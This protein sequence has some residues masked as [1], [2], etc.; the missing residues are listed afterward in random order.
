M[1]TQEVKRKLTTILSAD[2]KGYSRLMGEDEESTARTL[3]TYKE[4]LA[5]LIQHH[6][7][8]VVDAPGDN[9]LA[10]FGSV[11]DAVECAVEIQKELKAR[12]ADLPENRTMEFRIGVNL[13]DVI[14]ERDKILGDGVNITA[15]MESLSEAGGIC[16]SGTAFDQVKHK[17]PVGYQFLGRQTVKNIT[18]PVRAY[19]VMMEPEAAGKVIGEKEPKAT[20]WVWRAIAIV[21]AMVLVAAGLIWNFYLRGSQIEA[22]RVDKMAFPLP[23]KPSI[24][25]LPF[26]NMSEDS[27]QEYLADGITENIISALSQVPNIFVIAR[28]STFTYKGKP[29]KVQR[30]AEELGVRYVLEGSVQ[31]A[32][33]AVRITAQLID[34]ISG[35]H[36]WSE[37][38]DREIK[39]IFALQDDI[40]MK[41]I[42]ALRVTLTEG[43][44]ARA[45]TK[46]TDNLQAY[47]RYLQA[48]AFTATHTREGYAQARRL[49]EEV[50][51]LDPQFPE[52]Y[53]QLGVI[54]FS[55]ASR[56]ISK[57]P[58]ESLRQA[59]E[60]FKKTIAMDAS[61][62]HAHSFL[63]WI[64]VL[65]ER[66]YD[67]AVAECEQALALRPGS[68]LAHMWMGVVL[69]YAG[70]HEEA[71]R[72]LGQAIRFDP[73]PAGYVYRNYGTAYFHAERYEEAIVALKKSLD[74]A[75]NDFLTHAALAATYSWT[76]RL[77][78]ARKHAAEVLRI[79]PDFSVEERAKVSPYKNKADLDKYV[80]GLR[81]AGLK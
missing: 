61:N 78:E 10:E 70:R 52:A 45:A 35:H 24:A 49:L 55:E 25:V 28:N 67:A 68:P 5:G 54:H 33:D 1:T 79:K 2:V 77:E 72:S 53:S 34:A 41:V 50:I 31:I 18:E 27:K 69:L 23:D 13:G 26:T 16:I 75:P 44:R 19:K 7:G 42:T 17:L 60:M 30:V 37:R 74:C 29:V 81:R 12:N 63:G 58:A 51:T 80:E 62:A 76:D 22:A 36:V 4:V 15:R 47:L 46:G 3:N 39:K 9:V 21:A 66:Q 71:I 59:R 32:G 64:H 65:R 8:R 73:I 6:H 20:K 11:V 40:T 57:S 14:E 48:V 38:Y 56:G 43:E